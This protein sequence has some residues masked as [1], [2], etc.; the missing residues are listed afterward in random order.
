MAQ[1]QVEHARNLILRP[2]RARYRAGDVDLE[3]AGSAPIHEFT[4]ATRTG[5]AMPA[6]VYRAARPAPGNPVVV[7][8][9]GNGQNQLCVHGYADTE[10]LIALGISVCSF[11]FAGCG[12]GTEPL[13][14]MGWR[15][16]DELGNVIDAVKALGFGRV[17]LWGLSIGAFTTV[18]TLAERDDVACA[19]VDSAY[20]SIGSCLRHWKNGNV[21]VCE[22]A[23]GRIREDAGFD[24]DAVDAVAVAPRITAP[25]CFVHGLGDRTVPH[26]ESRKIFD[27]IGSSKKEYVTFPHGHVA[28]RGAEVNAKVIQ[29]IMECL[30]LPVP[31]ET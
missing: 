24:I 29:F 6:A 18:L 19:V 22:Q 9:H 11:D 31:A 7:F 20:S 10:R 21:E 2:P 23:R 16:K 1:G 3:L 28:P 12:N 15:E 8:S 14:T 13:I 25:V 30:G 27:A 26:Q 4:V 17:V 5:C